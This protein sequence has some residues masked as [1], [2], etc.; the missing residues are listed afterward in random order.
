M[1]TK[2]SIKNSQTKLKEEFNLKKEELISEVEDFCND[3]FSNDDG[4]LVF[5]NRSSVNVY[6]SITGTTAY[7]MLAY[8]GNCINLMSTKLSLEIMK[9]VAKSSGYE[10]GKRD[11]QCLVNHLKDSKEIS[12]AIFD[13]LTK[14]RYE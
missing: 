10:L 14:L 8:T 2:K 11:D 1:K 13:I 3:L 12:Q 7:C 9:A 5:I 4:V 6:D